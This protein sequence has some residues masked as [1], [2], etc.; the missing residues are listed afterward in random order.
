MTFTKRLHPGI[1]AGEITQTLRIWK[2]QRAKVGGRYP[3]EGGEIEVTR[4]REIELSDVTAD[5]ARRQ[6]FAGLVDLL[7]VAKHGAGQRVFLIDFE[8]RAAA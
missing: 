3:F 2:H 7:K 4:I 1:L 8:F 6:G 5:M